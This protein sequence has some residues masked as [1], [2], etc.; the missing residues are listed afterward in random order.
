[1][2]AHLLSEARVAVQAGQLDAAVGMLRQGIAQ[3]PGNGKLHAELGRLLILANRKNEG[4]KAL[5]RAAQLALDDW[6]IQAQV[7]RFFDRFR[8]HGMAAKCY[9][10]AL[11]LRPKD[12][13]L[14]CRLARVL[15]RDGDLRGAEHAAGGA[16][17]LETET[18]EAL[19]ELGLLRWTAKRSDEARKLCQAAVRLAPDNVI[20]QCA[21]QSLDAEAEAATRR[22][23]GLGAL[24]VG[25][26]LNKPFHFAYLQPIFA[27]LRAGH[28][29]RL[30]GE[31]G[32]L[33]DFEPQVVVIADIQG[34]A[35]RR[36]LPA[37]RFVYVRHGLV[38]KN[39]PIGGAAACDYYSNVTSEYIAELF[40]HANNLRRE[41]IWVTGYVPLDPLFRGAQMPLPFPLNRS[42]KTVLFAPTWNRHLSA[43]DLTRERTVELLRGARD[44][45][46]VIIKPHPHTIRNHPDWFVAFRNA[47]AGRAN[48]WLV[49]DP[50]ADVTPFL[51]AADVLVSD[52]SSVALAYLALDR[53]IVLVTHPRRQQDHGYN[54]EGLEWQWRD[55]GE[56]VTQIED[57]P[58]AV[59]RALVDPGRH[60]AQR[61]RYRE[62]LFGT[63][64]DGRAAERIAARIAEL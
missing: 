37:A 40:A 63:L 7:G 64:T 28:R 53:P 16:L 19:H 33:V 62:L 5:L 6:A 43:A 61:A 48:A 27:A 51:A 8:R 55:M 15:R 31:P 13:D 26:H 38:T 9:R 52:A 34:Q 24:R 3:S 25:F 36:M 45:F 2:T 49:E 4:E 17:R 10:R 57:L 11:D 23:E 47:V 56:E 21:A 59:E 12:V 35:M 22:S 29:V 58:A 50:A 20:Y 30:T 44:D 18:P 54:P 39:H 14:L 42:L 60:A 1:M 41:Q 46:N 32:L